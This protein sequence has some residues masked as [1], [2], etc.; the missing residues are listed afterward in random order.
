MNRSRHLGNNADKQWEAERRGAK[1]AEARLNNGIQE[2]KE[3]QSYHINSMAKEQKQ[4]QKDLLRI[5]QATAKKTT[6][7]AIVKENHKTGQTSQGES[8]RSQPATFL[9]GQVIA[10]SSSMALQMRI[11]DFMDGVS[12]TKAKAESEVTPKN[13]AESS[14]SGSSTKDS[15]VSATRRRSIVNEGTNS[16]NHIMQV[17][18]SELPVDSFD[19]TPPSVVKSSNEE[20]PVKPPPLGPQFMRRRSS[21]KPLFDEEIYAPD[22]ALRTQHTMPDFM[23]S[24][25]EAK[26]ARYIRHKVKPE[27]EKELSVAEIFQEDNRGTSK[28]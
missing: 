6:R 22:G 13:E 25:E 2:L 10:S 1:R 17:K 23:E 11:N 9:E 19:K 15:K 20:I 16:K 24:L 26:H 5:K 12:S 18:S 4:L 28:P 8:M 3:A 21:L 14:V 7:Q 27:S